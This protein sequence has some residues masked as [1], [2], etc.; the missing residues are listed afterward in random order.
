MKKSL[1]SWLPVLLLAVY[2]WPVTV[3]PLYEVDPTPINPYAGEEVHKLLSYLTELYGTYI[4]SGQQDLTWDDSVSMPD[5]VRQITDKHPAMMGYDFMNYHRKGLDDGSGLRQVE[6]AIEWWNK[7]GIISFC[8]HWR[9][10]SL[11]T[12]AFYTEQTDFIIDLD[13][14]E[15]R[16][17]LIKDIDL[18]AQDL[19]VL[20]EAGVPVLWRPLHEASGGWFWWGANGPEPFIKLWRLMVDRLNNHHG[21]NNLIWVYN[22]QNPD[23]YPGD[24]YVDIIS[25][26]TY[27]QL[28]DSQPDYSSQAERF[29]TAA[30]TPKKSMIVALTENGT[31]PDPDEM[32]KDNAMW[33]WFMTWNDSRDKNSPDSFFS[34]TKWNSHDHK[35]KVYNHPKV[36]TLEDVANR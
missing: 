17:Q 29:R 13:D 11:E 10:P 3:N 8:W 14:P 23:W 2:A 6:E 28:I 22:G 4:L 9:D 16:G 26:D 21:L 19:K 5:R 35:I 34:G 32:I 12:I 20:E 33:S 24:D 30:E 1:Y 7:G 18:I 27:P 25:E 36:L 31:I 15:V